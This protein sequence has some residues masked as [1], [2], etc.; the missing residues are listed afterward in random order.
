[1]VSYNDFVEEIPIT[2]YEQLMRILQGKT[3]NFREKYIFRGLSSDKYKLIPSALRKDANN[4]PTLNNFIDSDF[5]VLWAKPVEQYYKEGKISKER[6]EQSKKNA[7][8]LLRIDESVKF[9]GL[10]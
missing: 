1:M 8:N 9:Y 7:I 3:P 4:N 10:I 6:F 5:W 2:T